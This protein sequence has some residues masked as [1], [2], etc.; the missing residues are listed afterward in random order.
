MTV[1]KNLPARPFL[2]VDGMSLLF[3]SFY[4][5]P[6]LTNRHGHPTNAIHGFFSILFKLIEDLNPG[7]IAICFDRKETTTRKEAYSE[8]KAG[9]PE[10]P[11]DLVQQIPVVKN[12]VEV[13]KLNL[14]E[15]AGQE[16]DDLIATL[17]HQNHT[18]IPCVIYSSDFDLLQSVNNNT[19]VITPN[20]QKQGTLTDHKAVIEKYG[21]SSDQIPDYKALRGDS[22]DN[23]PGIKGIGEKTA[24]QL[25][26]TYQ[27][28]DNIYSNLQELSSNLQK[29]LIEGR[30]MALFCK[31]LA[32]LDTN[33][34]I[35]IP[36]T[37]FD[38]TKI[39]FPAGQTFL[40]ELD[41]NSLNK[42]LD[43]LQKKQTAHN[44]STTPPPET[45]QQT[46]F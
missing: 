38:S 2:I 20:N 46:L 1:Y 43:Q 27:T 19:F 21:I 36:E 10:A 7:K 29:K 5:I 9:R 12:G 32:T 25:L 18:N 44:S 6:K 39:D 24:V 45:Q 3:R 13:F 23:L 41:L 14:I 28:L 34:E 42:R 35:T 37:D 31:K 16:A 26:Q 33:L 30:E 4:A 15:Q 40:S 22:S 17:C 8:Y 11:S